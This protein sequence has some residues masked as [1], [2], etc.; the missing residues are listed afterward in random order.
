M[1]KVEFPWL[2]ELTPLGAVSEVPRT[3]RD[4][5]LA[6][7]AV[8]FLRPHASK[9]ALLSLLIA[10]A[11]LGR[12][13]NSHAQDTKPEENPDLLLM[14]LVAIPKGHLI[15]TEALSEVPIRAGTLSK[16]QRLRALV[17]DHLPRLRYAIVA[18]R[19]IAPQTPIFWTDL[20]LKP[21]PKS[22][23]SLRKTRVFF[24]APRGAL[25]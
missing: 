17:P 14:S 15:P 21:A 2:K 11:L 13:T 22:A 18:K 10:L 24:D 25:P 5:F 19:D 6:Y 7:P 12:C 3:R 20:M 9:I 16:A 1:E 8:T 23:K 4:R